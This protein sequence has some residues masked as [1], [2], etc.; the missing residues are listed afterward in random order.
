MTSSSRKISDLLNKRGFVKGTNRY[1]GGFVTSRGGLIKAESQKKSEVGQDAQKLDESLENFKKPNS[2]LDVSQKIAKTGETVPIVFGKRANNIG[3]VW[4]QP[5]LIK[6]GTSSYVQKLLFVISQGEIVSSP[7]K[8]RSFTG[9]RKLSFLDDTSITL[10]HIYSTAASL[11]SSPNSCPISSTDLFCGNDIYTYLSELFKASSGSYLSNEPDK[12]KDFEGL[13]V[14]TFGT[15]DTSNT[16]FVLS[17]QVFDAE[18]GDNVTTAY[19]TYLGANSMQFG[20][21]QRY[22]SNLNFLG[23]NNPGTIIDYMATFF[24]G[25]LL[26]PINATTVAAGTYTQTQLNNLNAISGGRTKFINKWTFVS[27]NNQVIS[28]NPASTG[29]LDGV[30]YEQTIG[31]SA[32]IQ[33]TS[34]DNSSFADITFLA[35]SGNLFETPSAGTFPSTTKQLYIFYEQGVKVDLFS[36]GL[37][38]S[39][40]TQGASNQFIDLA[41]HLFK[42]YKKIDGNNTATIVAPVEL[43][44]LQSLSTFCTNNSM[45]FNGIISKAVNIVDFIT[46]T[47]PYYFLSFLSVGGKYQFAPILPINGSNQIDTTALT[48]TMTF[49]EANIIQ[50]TFKKGYLSVEERREFIANCIYTECIPTEVAR[51]KTVSVRFSTSALDAPTEQFDMSDFCADVNH[52]ILYGKYE[53]A[54]RKHST[55]NISFSTPLL[56]TTLIP[57]N[58]IKLQ[59]QRK[60]SIGD[61]RTEIEYYQVSSITYDNDGVSNIEAAHFPLDTNDKSEISLEITTGTFT[62]LQ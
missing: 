56:T 42:L 3:G 37:S 21:N 38:G 60:N 50:G 10:T 13:K 7:T 14:K 1:I 59:L 11:A 53:L 48:P 35:V 8:S 33:N 17:L 6:A 61:D 62:V 9:L 40:Y 36:A 43:S 57:T 55:H 22:D 54:R 32:V 27:V 58:I 18:T 41:M 52:A 20:F 5:S 34:N 28:S 24:N 44:N 23:G 45:F 29:T 49:T 46:Q 47:S 26:P 25:Q 4:M 31:T 12:G 16:T 19:Q 51:R 39:S 15:G 2:D 30:Q